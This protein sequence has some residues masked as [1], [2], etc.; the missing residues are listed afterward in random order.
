[1][2]GIV[3]VAVF[4]GII[5]TTTEKVLGSFKAQAANSAETGVKKTDL[6][7]IPPQKLQEEPGFNAREYDDPD[8][9]AQIEAFAQ[10]YSDGTYVPPLI[11]RIDSVTGDFFI[12]DGH[13]RRRG[14]ML[15]IERGAP[16]EHLD[17]LP[18]RGNDM[19]RVLLMLTSAE[20]LK[21]KPLG[22]ADSYLRLN[23]MGKTSAEIA[24]RVN[25]TASHIDAMLV[26]AT[27]NSDVHALVRRGDV[28]A[29]T[30]IDAV[31][32]H[33]EKAGAFLAGKLQ[34]VQ[35]KGKKTLKPSAIKQWVPPRKMVVSLYESIEP[36]FKSLEA[37]EEAMALLTETDDPSQVEGM[38]VW[39]DA[40]ALKNLYRVFQDAEALKQKHSTE[41][42]PAS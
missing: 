21:L 5:M 30:A 39:V 19:D 32:T 10:A 13:Q 27:A 17:C 12:V 34:E 7:R 29:T 36:I 9:Q 37:Q 41:P 20:G 2:G 38:K 18:F 35:A 33:G 42:T 8:V 24:K 23:R 15:A 25:R 31:R 28:A 22:V 11:V 14:A 3:F 4:L 6:Y 16:I 40:A 1:M 26:L